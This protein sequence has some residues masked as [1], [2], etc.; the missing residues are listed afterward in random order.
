MYYVPGEIEKPFPMNRRL[1]V[2]NIGVWTNLRPKVFR[3][4]AART[5]QRYAGTTRMKSRLA[6]IGSNQFKAL[7][8]NLRRAMLKKINSVSTNE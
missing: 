3:N 2:T 1:I 7:P 4:A 6:L 5:I 8:A